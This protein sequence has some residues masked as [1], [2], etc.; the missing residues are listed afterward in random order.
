MGAFS[1]NALGN[2]LR[3]KGSHLTIKQLRRNDRTLE[4]PKV[5]DP[6]AEDKNFRHSSSI[7]QIITQLRGAFSLNRGY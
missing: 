7:K 3:G 6:E 5:R 4:T 2:A 1:L